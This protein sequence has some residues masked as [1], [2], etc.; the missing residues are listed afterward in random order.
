VGDNLK[1]SQN[2]NGIRAWRNIRSENRINIREVA[3]T[4]LKFDVSQH[5]QFTC[6]AQ[7]EIEDEKESEKI[8][9]M[10]KSSL[11]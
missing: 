4:P 2:K 9:H 7:K 3:L 10:T 6:N 5:K 11:E 1:W 8:Q